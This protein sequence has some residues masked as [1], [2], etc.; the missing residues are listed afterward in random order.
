MLVVAAVVLIVPYAIARA[1]RLAYVFDPL[2]ERASGTE[3]SRLDRWVLYGSGWVSFFV[4]L[5]LPLKLGE[6]SR[7]L[8]LAKSRQPGIGLAESISGVAAERLVDGLLICGMLFGGLALSDV[9][10][11]ASGALADVRWVGQAFLGMFGLGLAILTLAARDPEQASRSARRLLARISPALGERVGSIVERFAVA[12][13]SV[14]A[15]R[16]AVRFLVV[17]VVYWAITVAQL[18]LVLWGCGLDL[19][20]PEAAA[21]VALV[22][23]SIQLPGGPAQAGIYQFGSGVA[24]SLFLPDAVVRDAGSA[25]TAVMYVLQFVGTAAMALPGLLLLART[26]PA[27]PSRDPEDAVADPSSRA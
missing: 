15:L 22:G 18:W 8:L 2:V 1:H 10:P 14:L 3:S 24:L 26:R 7:P 27:P 20:W 11:W 21:I 16:Q 13:A 23:L 12:F 19:G 25:F 4:L 17:S 9:S 6:L 5:V